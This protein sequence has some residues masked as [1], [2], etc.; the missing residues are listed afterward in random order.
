MIK[1][2][3]SKL[4]SDFYKLITNCEELT[5]QVILLNILI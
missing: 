2:D 1:I 3:I 4:T 5:F